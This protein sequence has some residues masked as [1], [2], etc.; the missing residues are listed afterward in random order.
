MLIPSHTI[1]ETSTPKAG[2]TTALVG[3]SSHS[4]GK[5][6]RLKGKVVVGAVGYQESTTRQSI[7]KDSR[8]K[9]ISEYRAVGATHDA[10]SESSK[11]E[12]RRTE[13]GED[14]TTSDREGEG[15]DDTWASP[16]GEYTRDAKAG[17]GESAEHD[18]RRETAL[19]IVV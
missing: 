12:S 10:V 14:V 8:F 7:R 16:D 4:V 5:T 19:S 3:L 2:G 1:G 11:D 17:K 9:K 6:Q 13:G 18:S 15:K